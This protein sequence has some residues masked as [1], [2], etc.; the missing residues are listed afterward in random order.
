MGQ[1]AVE[2]K[3]VSDKT[4]I[5]DPEIMEAPRWLVER[6]EWLR[7]LPKPSLERVKRQFASA[8]RARKRLGINI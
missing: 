3:D 4:K 8:A 2:G 6:M 7:Q 5:K 1:R